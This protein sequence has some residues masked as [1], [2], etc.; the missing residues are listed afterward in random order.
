VAVI[1]IQVNPLC[2]QVVEDLGTVLAPGAALGRIVVLVRYWLAGDN[3]RAQQFSPGTFPEGLQGT[4]IMPCT[5][6]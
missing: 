4:G 3:P 1:G 6:I 2:A 5:V